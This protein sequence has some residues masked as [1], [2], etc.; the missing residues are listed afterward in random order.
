[1]VPN[2]AQSWL[3][4]ARFQPFLDEA[5]GDHERALELYDWHADLAAA[6][7]GMVHHFEVL[8]RNAI[9]AVLGDGQPQDPIRDTWL[10][11]FGILQPDGVKQV[12]VA[13]ERLDR[14]KAVT[15]G[16]VVAG[17]S[18]GFWAGLFSKTYEELWRHQ[19]RHAFPH[20]SVV[21]RDL[22]QRMRLLQRFRN[23]I[24]HH[25]CLLKQDIATRCDDMLLIAG[26]ID[27]HAER[28]LAERTRVPALLD[29]RPI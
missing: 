28:W 17:V 2:Q 7:F 22:T 18:F 15:R 23:R 11:D 21:R 4:S 24:A 3:S 27:P 6:C 14:G 13:V 9:D 8:V 26:W 12:I 25:D 16:R 19:L 5:A 20:G 10:M 1:M 29:A